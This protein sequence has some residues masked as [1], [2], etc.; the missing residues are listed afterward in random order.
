MKWTLYLDIGKSLPHSKNGEI[1]KNSIEYNMRI[2]KN[3]IVKPNELTLMVDLMLL[4]HFLVLP[5][6]DLNCSM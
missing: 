2:V 3:T 6:W 1:I 4:K 5:S